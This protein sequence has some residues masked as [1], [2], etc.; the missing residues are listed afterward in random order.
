MVMAVLYFDV[1]D[2]DG[3]QGAMAG[4]GSLFEG[5]AGFNGFELRRGVEE[6]ARFLLTADWDS[7]ETHTAWQ[8]A[9]AQAFLG[10]LSPFIERPP[11]IKHFRQVMPTT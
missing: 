5:V 3:F 9:H 8:A 6:P 11:D 2:A 10:A 1:K 7:V 4:S